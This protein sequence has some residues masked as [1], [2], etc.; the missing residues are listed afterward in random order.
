MILNFNKI[1][2]NLNEYHYFI[3]NTL[4]SEFSWFLVFI[5][6]IEMVISFFE[7]ILFRSIIRSITT[8]LIL[9]VFVESRS[10]GLLF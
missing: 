6:C 9:M 10:N 2:I 8:W 4:Y 7:V 3:K 5:L 1:R